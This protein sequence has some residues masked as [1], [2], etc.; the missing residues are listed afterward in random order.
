[1]TDKELRKL[2]RNELFEIML[3]QGREIDLLKQKIADL[4]A[5]LESREIR[6]QEAGSIAEAAVGLSAVF[7]EAQRAADL[8]VEN[9]KRQ[10][11]EAADA[12]EETRRAAIEEACRAAVAELKQS[13]EAE[14][15]AETEA[16]EAEAEAAAEAEETAQ[17]PDEAVTETGSDETEIIT[18]TP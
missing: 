3:A 5:A 17:S 14:A 7:E 15:T 4:E 2:R 6:I 8:Y 11:Q 18:E 13:A 9:V 16:A 12:A 1:M 10:M